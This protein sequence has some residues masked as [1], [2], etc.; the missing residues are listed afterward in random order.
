MVVTKI[1]QYTEAKLGIALP[2]SIQM[3]GGAML[4]DYLFTVLTLLLAWA[5]LIHFE[6]I[7][8]SPQE[9]AAMFSDK[10]QNIIS[11]VG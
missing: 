11:R 4:K 3:G 8:Y 2:Y 1:T 5:A 9:F 7:P 10:L 6:V